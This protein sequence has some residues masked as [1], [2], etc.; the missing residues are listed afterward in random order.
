M[1]VQM[2]NRPPGDG[3]FVRLH[4]GP[5]S[6]ILKRRNLIGEISDDVRCLDRER[7]E[8]PT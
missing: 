7:Q 3:S 4:K 5:G 2:K 1:F 6:V 8:E